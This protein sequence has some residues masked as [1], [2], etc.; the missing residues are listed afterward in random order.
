MFSLKV[1]FLKLDVG[2]VEYIFTR[3][4]VLKKAMNIIGFHVYIHFI[5]LNPW[6]TINLSLMNIKKTRLR[7]FM[8]RKEIKMG[9]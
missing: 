6:K 9:A 3:N 1:A 8:K 7:S 2:K 4:K 5:K